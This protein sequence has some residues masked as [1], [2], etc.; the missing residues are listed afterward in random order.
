MINSR[1]GTGMLGSRADRLAHYVRLMRPHQ[2]IKNLAIF[3][4]VIFSFNLFNG[5]IVVASIIGF[6]SFCVVSSSAYG[7]N[8]LLDAESDRRHPKKRMR[9]VASGAISKSGALIFSL[10]LL[11][12]G[13]VLAYRANEWLTLIVAAYWASNLLYSL[14][15]KRVVLL[16]VMTIGFGF[17][18]RVIGGTVISLVS[19]SS[20]LLLATFFLALFLALGKRR[21]ELRLQFTGDGSTRLVLAEYDTAI[22]DQLLPVMAGLVIIV[23]SLFS[24]SE[25][26]T[27]RFGSNLIIYTVPFVVYGLFRYIYLLHRSAEGEDPSLLLLG[28]RPMMVCVTL[29][30]LACVAIIYWARI[31]SLI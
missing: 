25:Y 10:A 16:D 6:L 22:I 11:A 2:W 5:V 8:D 19:P 4:P 31:V 24:I 21:E 17:V 30:A 15:L 18:L 26:A 1:A 12:T 9:P 23:Y 28:D 3:V 13:L 29:W 27:A 7:M 20:W 14:V